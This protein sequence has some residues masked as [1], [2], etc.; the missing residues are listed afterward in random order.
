MIEP[1]IKVKNLKIVYNEGKSN[2]YYALRG[3]SLEIYPNE[4][5]ILFGPSGCGKSTLLY[6]L[7]GIL[8]PSSGEILIKNENPYKYNVK[9]M[10]HFQR[11]TVGIIYQSFNLIPSLSVLDNVALPLIF[12][13]VPKGERDRR[14]MQLLKRFGVNQQAHKLSTNLSGGQSQRVAVARSL[15]N[16]PEILFADEPVGNLDSL[17]A[18]QVMG[19]LEEINIK[20]K[21]TVILVTHDAKLLPYAHRVYYLKDG[22]VERE[23]VNPERKQIKQVDPGTS[24]LSEIEKLARIYPYATQEELRVKSVVNFLTQDIGFDQVER[25]EKDVRDYIEGKFTDDMF[26]GSLTKSVEAGGPE[27]DARRADLFKEKI[28]IILKEAREIRAYRDNFRARVAS[29]R[30]ADRIAEVRRDVVRECGATFTPEQEARLDE[31][32]KFRIRG[33]IQQEDFRRRLETP[34]D[35]D[36]LGLDA[37]TARHASW[38]LEKLLGQG[39][40]I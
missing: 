37:T 25:L 22:Q 36:G 34:F 13:N 20:D 27:I 23:V 8:A 10:V 32:I 2:E 30:Q 6:S 3:E 1:I 33:F 11:A 35:A 40:Y 31:L 5:I 24:V 7:L 38:Y 17:S 19:T 15:V 4:Y 26:V 29:P 12:A 14:G 16:D 28:N 18:D 9:E 39:M 21:K